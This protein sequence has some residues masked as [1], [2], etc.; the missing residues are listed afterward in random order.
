TRRQAL[1]LLAPPRTPRPRQCIDRSIYR[2]EIGIKAAEFRDLRASLCL[3]VLESQ[4]PIPCQVPQDPRDEPSVLS[5]RPRPS[6]AALSAS[7]D[8]NLDTQ[9]RPAPCAAHFHHARSLST[10]T[11]PR[12]SRRARSPPGSPPTSPGPSVV[13]LCDIFNARPPHDPN[14]VRAGCTLS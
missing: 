9:H 3:R 6:S 5:A 2:F 10:H 12:R 11:T 14:C 8:I 4:I 1:R 13:T 7:N